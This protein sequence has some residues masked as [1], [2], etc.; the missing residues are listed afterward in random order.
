MIAQADNM[1]SLVSGYGW[2]VMIAA[3][4]LAG[5]ILMLSIIF[6]RRLGRRRRVML[7]RS[8]EQRRA[9]KG[10][11]HKDVWQEGS[12]RYID[13][14]RL[15]P[16]EIAQRAAPPPEPQEEDTP[17]DGKTG[18][19]APPW[20]DAEEAEPEDDPFG[21]MEDKPYQDP[22]PDEDDEDEGDE[23]WR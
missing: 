23:P 15:T 8:I 12:Q 22:D 19:E 10:P 20:D 13:R 3:L 6:A 11:E 14:D 1:D 5:V 9:K 2:L 16:E 21:L 7:D 18:G 4:G 17:G